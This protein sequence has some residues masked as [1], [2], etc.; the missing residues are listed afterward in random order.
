[1][2]EHQN[3]Q[4]GEQQ[5]HCATGGDGDTQQMP[6][7]I[8]FVEFESSVEF[9]APKTAA[10]SQHV[11]YRQ[12]HQLLNA[13]R[14]DQDRILAQNEDR[15]HGESCRDNDRGRRH[16]GIKIPERRE[17][18]GDEDTIASRDESAQ[19]NNIM[20]GVRGIFLIIAMLILL[21]EV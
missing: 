8:D 14:Q 20:R 11:D 4:Q 6:P 21:G 3:Y 18:K 9:T 5:N 10:S 1:M 13:G 19:T 17:K 15:H 12:P 16:N 7:P 2:Q